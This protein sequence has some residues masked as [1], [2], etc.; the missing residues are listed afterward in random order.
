MQAALKE[1]D[2]KYKTELVAIEDIEDDETQPVYDSDATQE[3]GKKPLD[4]TLTWFPK[5]GGGWFPK[6]MVEM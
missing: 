2:E 1:Q 4:Q 3:P 6:E 5:D